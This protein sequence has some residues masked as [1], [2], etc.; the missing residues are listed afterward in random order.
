MKIGELARAAHCDVETVRFYERAGLLDEPEREASG[1]RRY[2]EPHLRRL[3]FI[4]HCRSLDI[5]LSEI[6]QLLDFAAAPVQSCAAVDEL[7]DRQVALVRQRL[8]A[9]RA[10]EQQLTKLRRTCKGGRSDPCAI[11]ASFTSAADAHAWACH[12]ASP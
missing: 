3:R 6:R 2:D 10:L 8:D 7:L 12:P 4:R 1:Y 9:L 5:P 11:L